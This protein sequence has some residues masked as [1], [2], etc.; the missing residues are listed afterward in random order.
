MRD[1]LTGA[2]AHRSVIKSFLSRRFD[3][4]LGHGGNKM[5]IVLKEREALLEDKFRRIRIDRGARLQCVI[6]RPHSDHC[7]E[8]RPFHSFHAEDNILRGHLS[9]I[10]PQD[11]LFERERPFRGVLVVAPGL[12]RSQGG[13]ILTILISHDIIRV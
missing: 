4:C 3:I 9:P 11:S 2:I 8:L 12:R 1:K 10:M 5:H 6:E 13:I 7:A